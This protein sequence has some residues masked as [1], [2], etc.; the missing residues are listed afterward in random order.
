M[1]VVLQTD[2]VHALRML[3]ETIVFCKFR[4]QMLPY[5]IFCPLKLHS[6]VHLQYST[7]APPRSICRHS[8][9]LPFIQN[10]MHSLRW[11]CLSLPALKH[12]FD[13]V[14]WNKTKFQW[15]SFDDQPCLW[16]FVSFMLM[17]TI[18][19]CCWIPCH[20]LLSSSSA[21]I[22]AVIHSV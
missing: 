13:C 8:S 7:E 4:C 9:L 16:L 14:R 11:S 21:S 19:S 15:S 10:T 18:P 1:C 22:Q 5:Y 12:P 6:M 20:A 17:L 3:I 2:H